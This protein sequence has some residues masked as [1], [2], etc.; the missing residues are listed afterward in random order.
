M[1]STKDKTRESPGPRPSFTG[2]T[3]SD[4]RWFRAVLDAAVDGIVHINPAGIIQSVN[5]SIEKMFGYASEELVGQNVKMLMPAPWREEHDGYLANYMAT[6]KARII[7]IGRQV[8]GRRRDGST[9]P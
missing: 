3:E 6:G 7:G 8:E 1:S 9:F 2:S 5:P 4:A